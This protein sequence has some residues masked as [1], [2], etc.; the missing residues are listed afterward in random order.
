MSPEPAAGAARSAVRTAVAALLALG[1]AA[2]TT[3]VLEAFLPTGL[4]P[5]RSYVSEL[6]A[7]DQPYG[8]FFRSLDFGAGVLVCAGAVLALLRGARPAGLTRGLALLTTLGWVGVAVFG[9]AT[10]ADSRL[11]LSCAPTADAACAARE[12]AG[13]VPAAHSAHAVSSS[14]AVAGALVGMVLL[15]VVVRKAG[16]RAGVRAGG[17]LALLLGVELAATVW[18]LAAVAAFDAG[19][20]TWGLGVAQRLQLLTIAVWLVGVAWLVRGWGAA[21]SRR[22]PRGG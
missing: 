12:R 10:A 13:L 22:R 21:G 9:A 20:G 14:V 1:A 5:L 18:T 2:Y 17:L 11:P 16:A 6:A 15:T 19:H 4:S 7:T 3:W 8:T